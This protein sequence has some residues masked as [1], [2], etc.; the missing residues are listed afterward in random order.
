MKLKVYKGSDRVLREPAEKVEVFDMELQTLIDNMIETM[1]AS[2]G[3]G[4]AAPQVGISKKVLVCEFQLEEGEENKEDEEGYK[5][6]PLTVLCNPKV[7]ELSRDECKMVEGCLS[8]P[9]LE[10]V[11]KRPKKITVSGQDRYGKDIEISAEDLYGRVLQHEID[12][13]NSTL[14]VDHIKEMSVV[15]F[16]TGDF[17]LH[18]LESLHRDPQY[19]VM[20]VVTGSAMKISRGKSRDENNIKHL[21]KKYGI[22]VIEVKSLKDDGTI[23]AIKKLKPD[24][25]VVTDFG[26]IIPKEIIGIPGHGIINIH[27]SILPKYRGST[28][29]QSAILAGDKS[30]GVSLIKIDEGVDS[31]PIIAQ[32]KIRLSGSENYQ[33]LFD[34]L[35][36]VGASLLLS[37][38][39]YYITGDL[40]P[41][42]QND[43]RATYAKIL[44]KEDG[45]VT[46]ETSGI[47]VDRKIRAL[48]PW[49]GTYINVKNMRLLLT[50]AHLDKEK[51]LVIDR[52]KP[53]GKNEMSYEDFK[54][55]YQQELTFSK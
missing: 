50:A 21:A 33:I 26:F 31:G 13:L 15:F 22:P 2:D 19:K 35:S 49:P 54:N 55:G 24:L 1:R 16:A 34:Y 14:F 44:K 38:L 40:K 37:A 8:F 5:T 3:I 52:V 29:I 41:K 17:G 30:I 23:K 36:E 28:P 39:P 12:H 42:K 27:P 20:A 46:L 48:Y 7:K 25:G 32:T 9:G 43:N 10:L 51:N 18:A 6:F 45:E 4:L 53:A 11:V 47:E